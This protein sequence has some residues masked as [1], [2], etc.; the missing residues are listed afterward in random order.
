MKKNIILLIGF[1][2]FAQISIFAMDCCAKDD[3]HAGHSSSK[4]KETKTGGKDIVINRAVEPENIGN[5]ICPVTGDKIDEKTKVAYEYKGKIYDFCC[6]ACIDE[7]KKD[8][9]KFIKK[10]EEE[11]QK[12]EG[13]MNMKVKDPVCKMEINSEEADA[14]SVYG[15]K[16]Y[17]FCSKACKEKFDK[18]PKKYIKE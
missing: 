3:G 2:L 7:F 6:A 16:T 17:Y 15:G 4:H 9:E 10:I 1:L 8:P 5:I 18:D 14:T 13:K 12:K 11:N